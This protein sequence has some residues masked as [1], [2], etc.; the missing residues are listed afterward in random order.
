MVRGRQ[1]AREAIKKALSSYRD[2]EAE[3]RQIAK[4]LEDIEARMSG[5]AAPNM[6][7]M[8][9]GSSPGD[10]TGNTATQHLTLVELYETQL[11]ILDATQLRVERLIGQLDDPRER[12]LLRYRYI[13]GM[14]WEEVCVAICYSWRQTHNVHARALDKLVE[15]DA[16]N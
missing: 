9:R 1:E 13:D 6:D 10:P 11:R 14:T 3:R 8:P 2:R 7:G 16:Q 5:P 4:Q 12:A 15:L